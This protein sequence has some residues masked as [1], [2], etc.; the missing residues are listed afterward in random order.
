M[1]AQPIKCINVMGFHLVYGL[2]I[3]SRGNKFSTA[4]KNGFITFKHFVDVKS[5]QDQMNDCYWVSKIF[6]L[7]FSNK[8]NSRH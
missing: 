2:L 1:I 4:T 7:S 3:I 6:Y 5:V 8:E